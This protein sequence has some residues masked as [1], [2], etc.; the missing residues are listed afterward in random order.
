MAQSLSH[1]EE[2]TSHRAGHPADAPGHH[3]EGSMDIAAQERTFEG[4]M[5]WVTRAAIVIVVALVFLALVN[6]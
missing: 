5:R 2:R 6:G 3:V 1:P 4:F